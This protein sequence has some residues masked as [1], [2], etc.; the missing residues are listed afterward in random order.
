MCLEEILIPAAGPRKSQLSPPRTQRHHQ[1]IE[2]GYRK[3]K[4]FSI[5]T[6]PSNMFICIFN[7]S[8]SV[9]FV[10]CRFISL[11]CRAQ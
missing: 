8:L 2:V 11:R 9:L 4:T 6:S 10:G 1:Q 5:K 3:R 7:T